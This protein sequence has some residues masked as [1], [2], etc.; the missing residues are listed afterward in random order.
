[1]EWHGHA[2]SGAA[3]GLAVAPLIP[4]PPAASLIAISGF[5]TTTVISTL[6]PDLDAPGSKIGRSLGPITWVLGHITHRASYLVYEATRTQQDTINRSRLRFSNPGHRTLT[7]TAL[8]AILAGLV[9]GIVASPTGWGV[10]IGTAVGLGCLT[11]VIGDMTTLWGCPIWWPIA[12]N[13][14]RWE[15]LHITPRFMRFKCGGKI[16]ERIATT[17]WTGAAWGMVVWDFANFA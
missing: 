9:A 4:H 5:T 17:L 6:I 16:G 11:H 12:I 2:A 15:L 13:G 10:L 3:T 7:H 14:A 8:F 1:M